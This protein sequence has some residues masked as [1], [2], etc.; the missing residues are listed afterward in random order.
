MK[1]LYNSNTGRVARPRLRQV[2]EYP[3]HLL[4]ELRGLEKHELTRMKIAVSMA[5]IKH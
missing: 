4:R 5:R 1:A 2:G 3:I